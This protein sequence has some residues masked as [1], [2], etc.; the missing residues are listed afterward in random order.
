VVPGTVDALRDACG[1]CALADE[2]L[3]LAIV[4]LGAAP[5]LVALAHGAL[6]G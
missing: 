5:L 4:L 3:F 6:W 1:A 2:V